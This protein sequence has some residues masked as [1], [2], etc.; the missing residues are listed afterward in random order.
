MGSV[1]YGSCVWV[2]VL[3]WV[4]GV[5]GVTRLADER[6]GS[7]TEAVCLGRRLARTRVTR[8]IKMGHRAISQ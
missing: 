4:G 8:H 3:P 6:G 1:C 7:F 2:Q 5:G